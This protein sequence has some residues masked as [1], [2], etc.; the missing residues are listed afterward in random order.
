MSGSN[1]KTKNGKV[2]GGTKYGK[3]TQGLQTNWHIPHKV[4]VQ[5]NEDDETEQNIWS[6]GMLDAKDGEIKY[7]LDFESTPRLQTVLT[8]QSTS[9]KIPGN[10]TALFQLEFSAS[11]TAWLQMAEQQTCYWTQPY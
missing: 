9:R 1:L 5:E 8:T 6:T 10:Q 7:N 11:F 2:R 3:S 4:T